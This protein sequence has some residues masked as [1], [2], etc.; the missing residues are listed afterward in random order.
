[1]KT[2]TMSAE[3]MQA[4]PDG[5][6][7]DAG[8]PDGNE[9]MAADTMKADCMKKAEMETD[10]MK[11]ETMTAECNAMVGDAMKQ[12]TR[13]RRSSS[14]FTCSREGRCAARFI[15]GR[16][17]HSRK[18]RRRRRSGSTERSTTSGWSHR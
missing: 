4:D 12:S 14:H 8:R 1:M 5:H 17:V 18:Q 3:P 10:A 13:W 6:R 7:R 2:N 15:A 11:K 9:C 16:V